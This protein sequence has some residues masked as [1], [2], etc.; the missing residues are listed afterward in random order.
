LGINDIHTLDDLA[1]VKALY[2]SIK[3]DGWAI[4]NAD[5][6]HCVKVGADLNCNVAY[7][8]DEDNS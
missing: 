3:K 2:Q 7:S 5:D 4:L 8:L 6:E 1:K